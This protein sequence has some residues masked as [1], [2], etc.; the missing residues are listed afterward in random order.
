M[1]LKHAIKDSM[2]IN[3]I[4]PYCQSRNVHIYSECLEAPLYG[5]I[6]YECKEC[7][8]H[9]YITREEYYQ[10]KPRE[11]PPQRER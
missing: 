3:G 1:N 8:T 2:L 10:H 6:I 11:R 5:Y 7:A 9:R 4:C